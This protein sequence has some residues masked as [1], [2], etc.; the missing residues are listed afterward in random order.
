MARTKLKTNEK[1]FASFFSG[2]GGF[3]YGLVQSGFI[4]IFFSDIDRACSE[5]HKLNFP[6]V[7]FICEDINKITER[8][9]S[10]IV[11]KKKVSLICGGPPCQGFT[12]MG[13]KLGADPRNSSLFGYMRMVRLLNPDFVVLENVPGLQKKFDGAFY[14]FLLSELANLGYQINSR[15]VNFHDWGVPQ[16]RKRL[17]IIASKFGRVS[18]DAPLKLPIK[19]T[20]SPKRTVGE[21]LKGLSAPDSANVDNHSP[22]NHGQVVIDRYKLIKPDRKSVV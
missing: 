11:K 9:I 5:T 2:G 7:P 22:L 12:N 18:L 3:D 15:V 21:A 6:D 10:T 19:K 17:I 14:N 13:D 16:I 4:P 20:L 8:Q 1:F